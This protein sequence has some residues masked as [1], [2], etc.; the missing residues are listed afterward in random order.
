MES[1]LLNLMRRELFSSTQNS[2]FRS[3]CSVQNCGTKK[4]VHRGILDV[5]TQG[6][7]PKCDFLCIDALMWVL[8]YAL[9]YVGTVMLIP[10]LYVHTC[11]ESHSNDLRIIST[12]TFSNPFFLL[13]AT[14]CS[15]SVCIFNAAYFGVQPVIHCCLTGNIPT[16]GFSMIGPDTNL[17]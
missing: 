5:S 10:I 14:V 16:T 13:L 6:H 17:L 8:L 12:V 7:F 2:P 4:T 11:Q 15:V 3:T 1:K 9:P